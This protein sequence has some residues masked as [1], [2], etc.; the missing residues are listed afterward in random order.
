MTMKIMMVTTESELPQ[1]EKALSAG[2]DEYLMKPFNKDAVF[3]K[4]QMLGLC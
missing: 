2:A 1:V 3:A 4:L